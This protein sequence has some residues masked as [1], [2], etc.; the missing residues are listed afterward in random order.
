[1]SLNKASGRF[2]FTHNQ[3]DSLFIKAAAIS[4]SLTIICKVYANFNLFNDAVKPK[5]RSQYTC[6]CECDPSCDSLYET[7]VRD[8]GCFVTP[9]L[10]TDDEDDDGKR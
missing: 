1:M 10:T 3:S 9:W 2:L 6:G 5:I 7:W 4:S 8:G